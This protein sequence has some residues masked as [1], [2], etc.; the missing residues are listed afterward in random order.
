MS[1]LKMCRRCFV[2]KPHSDFNKDASAADK[3]KYICRPCDREMQRLNRLQRGD[4]VRKWQ[5]DWRHRNLSK[6]RSGDARSHLKRACARYGMTVEDYLTVLHTQDSKCAICRTPQSEFSRR[7]AIDHC[8]TSKK[9]RGLLCLNCN[10]ALGLFKDSPSIMQQ[11][12]LY[13]KRYTQPETDHGL[14][15]QET[16]PNPAEGS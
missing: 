14:R 1:K 7:F 9:F 12:I 16:S 11:A 4:R 10:T 2:E 13:I 8:H 3:L 5:R 6:A 15:V